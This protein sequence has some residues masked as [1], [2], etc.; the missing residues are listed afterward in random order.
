MSKLNPV[1]V[2]LDAHQYNRAIKLASALP[3][4]NVLGKA[5]LAH[6][7]SKSGQRH[8]ALV[9]LNNIL[10][11]HFCELK[12]EVEYSIE[13][14]QE[15]Q[16]APV[17]QQQPEPV[18]A[19]NNK[20]GKKGKKKSAPAAKAPPPAPVPTVT[21]PERDLIDQLTIPPPLPDNW[22]VLPAAGADKAITDEVR[23]N[24]Y[25]LVV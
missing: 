5:L 16:S 13:A 8:A 18:A 23:E 17:Q 11:G 22:E 2:A 6:A 24:D 15:R 1:Y 21:V 20:K 3:D 9:L 10:G 12:H 25:C 7:Y 4:T 14:L 19:P